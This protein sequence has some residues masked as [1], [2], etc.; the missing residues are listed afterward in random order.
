MDITAE[1]VFQKMHTKRDAEPW[2]AGKKPT[3]PLVIPKS[4]PNLDPRPK[5]KDIRTVNQVLPQKDAKISVKDIL[6]DKYF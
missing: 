5:P 1:S 3:I 4:M 2:T 6:D